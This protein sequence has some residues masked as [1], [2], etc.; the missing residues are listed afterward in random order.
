MKKTLLLAVSLL[1]SFS[2]VAFAKTKT[3]TSLPYKSK[4]SNYGY[5][6]GV[7]ISKQIA[8]DIKQQHLPLNKTAILKGFKD[9]L[10]GKSAITDKQRASLMQ[11]LTKQVRESMQA[12]AKAMAAANKKKGVAFLAKNK[13]QKGVVTTKSGLQYQ[14]IKK[15]TGPHPG[16]TDTVVVDYEGSLLNKQVFDSSY[17]RHT[18]ATFAVNSVIPGWTEALQ[19]MQRGAKWKLFI[20]ANLAYGVRGAGA[21]IPPNS[22]LI[23]TVE[24]KDIKKAPKATKK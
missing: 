10:S 8:H 12:K 22:T 3:K 7:N 1:F 23:F 2:I 19:K 9:G 20:P 17:K 16:L 5:A 4:S 11:A 15:G 14:I 13:K 18:P 24:L 21:S 6:L